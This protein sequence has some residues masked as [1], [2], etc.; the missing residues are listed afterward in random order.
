MTPDTD[1]YLSSGMAVGY[2]GFDPTAPSL[3]IGNYLQI[4]ILT[5]FQQHGHKP[6]VLMGGATGRIGDPSFKD[7]ERP[8]KSPEELDNNLSKQKAQFKKL[9][10]FDSGPNAAVF[11]NNY[12]FYKDMNVLDFLR[13]VGKL[14]TINYMMSKDS[15]KKRIESGLS[16]TEFSYQL[17]QGYD[18]LQLYKIDQC[19]LQMGGSDQWGNIT[20]GTEIVRK[21]LNKK[22]YALTTPLLVKADGT[23]F[24]KSEGGNIWLDPTM[25]TPYQF[26]Q[27]WINTD[28]R[29]LEKLLKF[30]SLKPIQTIQTYIDTLVT[31]PQEVKQALAIEMT[32]RIHSEESLKSALKVSQLLF[33]PKTDRDWLQQLTCLDWEAISMEI[34][35]F[36]IKNE[37][38]NLNPISIEDMITQHTSI[39][40]SKS[41]FR[42]AIQSQAISVNKT[43][44]T[45]KDLLISKDYYFYG[46]Y[47]LFEN[48]KKNKF[49]LVLK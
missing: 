3:T 21:V 23:K 19:Q 39:F 16:F 4:M 47:L 45:D 32:Q 43:K 13:E 46:K 24:G 28:D 37:V 38:L 48:G 29:D 41:E 31:N 44:I 34:P 35:S 40:A 20:A 27:F 5:L 17:I 10:N 14:L 8:L 25:T 1:K 18:F 36:G 33:N 9:L 6:I 26:Y 49:L 42:R 7:S 2:I 15:V 11:R 12:D 30:F 22:V